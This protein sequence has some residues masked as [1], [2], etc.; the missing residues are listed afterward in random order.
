[1]TRCGNPQLILGQRVDHS[2]GARARPLRRTRGCFSGSSYSEFCGN[3]RSMTNATTC[4]CPLSSAI[5]GNEELLFF[6]RGVASMCYVVIVG[7]LLQ[8]FR[9]RSTLGS[10]VHKR[11]IIAAYTFVR[12]ELRRAWCAPDAQTRKVREVMEDLKVGRPAN[13]E[14][15]RRCIL[16]L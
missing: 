12:E 1:M 5:Q 2:P 3:A 4:R 6:S 15:H 11:H 10:M 9:H 13:R 7:C 8:S 16:M 14:N